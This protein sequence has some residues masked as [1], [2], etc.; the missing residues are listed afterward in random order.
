MRAPM[1]IARAMADAVINRSSANRGAPVGADI[2]WAKSRRQT[3]V[4][5]ISRLPTASG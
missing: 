2:G 3:K 1:R 5:A 4:R